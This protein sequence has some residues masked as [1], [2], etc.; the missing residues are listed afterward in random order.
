MAWWSGLPGRPASKS[1][2]PGEE[3]ESHVQQGECWRHSSGGVLNGQPAWW[4]SGRRW[5]YQSSGWKVCG[6][7]HSGRMCASAG[8]TSARW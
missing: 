3:G 5:R 4:R 1:M 2:L 6:A 8:A 7:R